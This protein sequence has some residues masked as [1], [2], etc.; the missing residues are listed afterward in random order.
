MMGKF[1]IRQI[2]RD[3]NEFEIAVQVRFSLGEPLI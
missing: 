2:C 3:F 1:I